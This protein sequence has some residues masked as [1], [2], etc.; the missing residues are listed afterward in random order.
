MNGLPENP[1]KSGLVLSGQPNCQVAEHCWDPVGRAI[2]EYAFRFERLIQA[3]N[4]EV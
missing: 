1:A 4:G 3:R 2:V